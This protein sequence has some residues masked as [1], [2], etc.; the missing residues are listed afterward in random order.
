MDRRTDDSNPGT[1]LFR[2]RPQIE[3]YSR[4]TIIACHRPDLIE[5]VVERSGIGRVPGQAT[6]SFERTGESTLVGDYP[7]RSIEVRIDRVGLVVIK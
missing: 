2:H 7:W 1:V 4:S 6:P 5:N 3:N